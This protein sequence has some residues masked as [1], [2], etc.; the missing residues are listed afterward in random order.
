MAKQF[1]LNNYLCEEQN[2]K[3]Y[4]DKT[5]CDGNSYNDL[6]SRMRDLSEISI[7]LA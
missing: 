5:S 7:F 4:Y 3:Q 2:I 6:S 1:I